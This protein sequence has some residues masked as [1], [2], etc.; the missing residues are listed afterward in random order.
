MMKKT[1]FAGLLLAAAA[2]IYLLIQVYTYFGIGLTLASAAASVLVLLLLFFCAKKKP[3][4][5][6]LLEMVLIAVLAVGVI[7]ASEVNE[8]TEKISTTVEYET[9]QLVC[10]KDSGIEETDSFADYDAGYLNKDTHSF[11]SL[12]DI[13][14]NNDKTVAKSSPYESTKSLYSSLQQGNTELMIITNDIKSDLM[15]ID[16][17][18]QDKVKVLFEI[19]YELEAIETKAVDITSEPFTI[20]LCGADLSSGEDINSTGR[21]DVNILLTVN[22]N[23]K[24]VNLQVIP[25]DTFVYI[26]CRGGS[27][28]LSYS[29]WWGGVQ[30]SIDSIEDKFDI[31]IN[32]F[33]KINFNGLTDLVDSLGGVTVYSHYTYYTGRNYFVEGEN[34][35]DGKKALDFVRARKMLPENERSRGY[36][37]MELI[38]GIFRKFAENPTYENAMAI[39]EG[40]SN[41][42]VTNLPKRD[43]QKAVSLVVEL[44]PQLQTMENHTIQGEYLWHYDEVRSGYYQ[45]YFYPYEGEIEAVKKRIDNVIKG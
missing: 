22:P 32:Y 21:G 11:E 35:V 33:A 38:K 19:Q 20:Y 16:E 42:F 13:L 3:L 41:N 39:M 40:L 31:E 1:A 34:F 14:E 4:I 27:S 2:C 28:K 37:Q 36:H 25:R 43:Y 24:K 29:G 8:V 45:Y 44:L 6:L 18:Y 10:L 7:G 12:I 9:V 23:T 30:S 26:P 17:E 5:A 15:T